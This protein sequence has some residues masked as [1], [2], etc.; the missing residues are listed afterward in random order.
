MVTV[1]Y[2]QERLRLIGLLALV[3]W[4]EPHIGHCARYQYQV[5]YESDEGYSPESIATI[6]RISLLQLNSGLTISI[7]AI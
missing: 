6:V 2:R 1:W 5:G 7:F 4:P 3:W